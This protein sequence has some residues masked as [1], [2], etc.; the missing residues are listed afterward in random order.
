MVVPLSR[1]A[2]NIFA[3]AL[4]AAMLW[5]IWQKMNQRELKDTMTNIKGMFSWKRGK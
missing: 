1:V 3:L 4:T 5:I 2:N